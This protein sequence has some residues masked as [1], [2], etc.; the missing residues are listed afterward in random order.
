M[1]NHLDN[2]RKNHSDHHFAPVPDSY[3]V[4]DLSGSEKIRF[5]LLCGLGLFSAGFLF[6]HSILLSLARF[7]DRLPGTRSVPQIPG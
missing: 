5:L 7:P 3:N 4:F 1:R 6:Y 2:H